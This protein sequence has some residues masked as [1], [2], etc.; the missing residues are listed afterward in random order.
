MLVE[1][2]AVGQMRWFQFCNCEHY[3]YMQQ[4]NTPAEPA[5]E[6]NIS[7]YR[8][9]RSCPPYQGLHY[10]ILLLSRKLLSKGFIVVKLKSLLRK[11]YVSQCDVVDCGGISVSQITT[12]MLLCRCVTDDHRYV[13]HCVT[14]DHRYVT[15]SLCP[16]FNRE[17]SMQCFVDS[18][19]VSLFCA[20]SIFNF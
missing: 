10:I 1:N 3:I 13:C 5:Y 7:V 2:N 8:Y 9:S 14:D 6:L 15:L 18:L 17:F 4:A 12:D 20:S 16:F 11:S 19:F